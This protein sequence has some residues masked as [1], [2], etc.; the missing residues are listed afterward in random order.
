MPTHRSQRYK[1]SDSVTGSNLTFETLRSLIKEA[2]DDGVSNLLRNLKS[3][4]RELKTLSKKV[5]KASGVAGKVEKLSESTNSR[6]TDIYETVIPKINEHMSNIATALTKRVLD[7]DVHR[8]K[9]SL[10]IQGIQ[11]A[12]S[13]DEKVTRAKVV[14]FAKN[15]LRIPDASLN[16]YGACHRLS[17][18]ASSGII[19]KFLDLSQRNAWLDSAKN[20]KRYPDCANVSI[21]PDLPNDLRP[22]KTE[23]LNKRKQLPPDQKKSSSIR[24]LKQWPYVE[25]RVKHH[26]TIRPSESVTNVCER[27]LG[28]NKNSLLLTIPEPERE[29][30]E[31]GA[32]TSEENDSEEEEE[33]VEDEANTGGGSDGTNDE[34]Q[35]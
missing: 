5:D 13:E 28:L 9:W 34:H 31:D 14:D 21:S 22:L 4:K 16:D 33:D 18:E 19:M 6:F 24:F 32:E 23:L 11:G 20:L 35:H 3:F 15:K 30:Q 7:L 26:P 25:L 27:V 17:Q 29:A 8:R 2:V 1:D 10:N 12:A